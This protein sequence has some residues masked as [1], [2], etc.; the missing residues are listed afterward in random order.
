MPTKKRSATGRGK[1]TTST[2]RAIRSPRSPVP[3]KR[4]AALEERLRSYALSFPETVEDSPWGDRAF[5]VKGKVF[6][7]TSRETEPLTFSV[8]LPQSATAALGLPFAAPTGYG[9][10]KSG[11]VTATVEDGRNAPVELFEEWI[12]ESWHAIAPK[13][14]VAASGRG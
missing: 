9:L 6:L 11:W 10:G 7:F 4:L 13:R 3:G 1:A 5:K 2:P 14:L 12:E 8:K